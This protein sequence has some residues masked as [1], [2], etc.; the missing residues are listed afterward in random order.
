MVVEAWQGYLP[1]DRQPDYPRYVLPL[2]QRHSSEYL[3][4]G[5]VGVSELDQDEVKK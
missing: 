2:E 1:T 3:G 4:V 5:D